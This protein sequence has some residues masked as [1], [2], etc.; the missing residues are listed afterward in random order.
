MVWDL[1]RSR[2]KHMAWKNGWR[3]CLWAQ[4]MCRFYYR[5]NNASSCHCLSTWGPRWGRNF[6][7]AF[8]WGR[9]E[10][11]KLLKTVRFS[12]V[13]GWRTIADK[14]FIDSAR[15]SS[16]GTQIKRRSCFTNRENLRI[17]DYNGKNQYIWDASITHWS[18]EWNTSGSW[19]EP[20]E[21]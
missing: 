9:S 2:S 10:N 20:C 11:W 3:R 7:I 1:R 18:S 12:M 4:N 14:G 5:W 17:R 8:D 13:A 16:D 15:L 19:R 21:R 6:A